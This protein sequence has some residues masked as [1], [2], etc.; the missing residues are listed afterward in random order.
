MGGNVDRRSPA[1]DLVAVVLL[2]RPKR[3]KIGEELRILL[4]LGGANDPCAT[5]S[6]RPVRNK[7]GEELRI[8][9]RLGGAN[10]GC[11]TRSRRP[12]RNKIASGP[13]RNKITARGRTSGSA[14]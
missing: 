10:D 11:A 13:E 12:V 1:A 7:I 14:G 2:G 6:R 8:L 9:L 3:N 5:R 4:R